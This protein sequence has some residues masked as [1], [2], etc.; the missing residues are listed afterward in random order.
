MKFPCSATHTDP[1]TSRPLLQHRLPKWPCQRTSPPDHATAQPTQ[2]EYLRESLGVN[3]LPASSR[4]A[5]SVVIA[6]EK[7]TI[8]G[9][10]GAAAY[11]FTALLATPAAALPAAALLAAC[12][13]SEEL[14]GDVAVVVASRDLGKLQ[15]EAA[16]AG[17]KVVVRVNGSEVTLRV[18]SELFFS[19]SAS[20]GGSA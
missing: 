4:P 17:G 19:A 2:A 5:G 16:A 3:V 14:A 7:T 8:G 10:D 1:D 18:G 13:G 11:P 12:G 20:V 6:S 9:A 15:A